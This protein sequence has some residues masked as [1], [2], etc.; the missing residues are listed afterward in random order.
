[1]AVSSLNQY[2]FGVETFLFEYSLF[3]RCKEFLG[4]N[5]IYRG[6]KNFKGRSSFR[7]GE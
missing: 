7:E 2:E 1:M 6:F 4:Y 3:C 5:L